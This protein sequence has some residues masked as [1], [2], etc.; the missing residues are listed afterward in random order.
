M[1]VFVSLVSSLTQVLAY[2]GAEIKPLRSRIS[3]PRRQ[4]AGVRP[5]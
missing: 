3:D 5:L 1:M 2:P 4:A